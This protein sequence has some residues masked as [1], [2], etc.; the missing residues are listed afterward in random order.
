MIERSAF[1]EGFTERLRNVL[2]KHAMEIAARADQA[3]PGHFGE[4]AQKFAQSHL[5]QSE[6]LTD[7]SIDELARYLC[8]AF[9]RPA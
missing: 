3:L 4:T 9:D 5:L 7:G 2:A 6:R 1:L 8:D